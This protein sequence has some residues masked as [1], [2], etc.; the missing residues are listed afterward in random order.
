MS[1]N[2]KEELVTPEVD[3]SKENIVTYESGTKVRLVAAPSFSTYDAKNPSN[4]YTGLYYVYDNK[5]R[6][7][8]IRLCDSLSKVGR[9]CMRL[10]WFVISDLILGHDV[11]ED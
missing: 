5:V 9:P 10:G 11:P 7:N 3:N 1:K 2:K 6:N 4:Y 8:R